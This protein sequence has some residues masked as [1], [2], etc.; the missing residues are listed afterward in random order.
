M[1]FFKTRGDRDFVGVCMKQHFKL[2]A[3][4]STE[5]RHRYM[6][7]AIQTG[8]PRIQRKEIDETASLSIV[9]YGPSLQDTWMNI[10]HPILTM[11]G[12]LR[13]LAERGVIPEFHCDMD[14]RMQKVKHI[15]PPIPGVHYLMASVC[16][17]QTWKI[18]KYQN[19]SIWHTWSAESTEE[20]LQKNDPGSLLIRGGSHIGVTSLQIG[21]LL[22]FR[23][24]EIYGM[25]GS[26]KEGKRHAG[27]HYGHSQ[28]GVTW[29][30]GRVTYQTSRIMSNGVVDVIN[31]FRLYPMFGVFHGEGLQQALLDEEYD[32]D[33]VA[34]EGTPKA[35]MV[36]GYKARIYG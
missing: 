19:V 14:P 3:A 15:N 20:W 25:D 34:L 6:K 21:G 22:G 23:H 33:N 17:P 5:E 7:F 10:K 24:F 8:L 26:I 32:L 9:A 18:L 36:R 2:T 27:P 11:S 31:A 30:A 28:G 1:S 13:F 16:H 35:N 29:D 4:V 12:S